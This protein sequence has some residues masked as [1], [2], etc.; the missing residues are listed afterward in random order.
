MP[1]TWQNL[2]ITWS[3]ASHFGWSGQKQIAP[4]RLRGRRWASA[5]CKP[6]NGRASCCVNPAA[7]NMP[8]YRV[9]RFVGR[10]TFKG[11]PLSRNAAANRSVAVGGAPRYA[12]RPAEAP[13]DEV[14]APEAS[15][16][17]HS[18]N[19]TYFSSILGNAWPST[20]ALTNAFNNFA[21]Q[22]RIPN[23]DRSWRLRGN[24][25]Q[26]VFAVDPSVLRFPSMDE[27][28]RGTAQGNG[29]GRKRTEYDPV[30]P[31]TRRDGSACAGA[32]DQ[33][34]ALRWFGPPRAVARPPLVN[35]PL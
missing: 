8:G 4:A 20:T 10:S 34:L 24:N 15:A 21:P 17:G 27:T 19:N 33:Y 1:P 7:V 5:V 14:I 12:Q 28:A 31:K 30:D 9:D 6:L 23:H 22:R 13:R 25:T 35:K 29:H 18:A 3:R 26:L 16:K 32:K 11:F 2:S